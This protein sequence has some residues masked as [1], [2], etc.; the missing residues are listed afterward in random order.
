MPCK[1]LAKLARSASRAANA[2]IIPKL[3]PIES[4]SVSQASPTWKADHRNRSGTR[5]SPAA[6]RNDDISHRFGPGQTVLISRH[7]SGKSVSLV[8]VRP[9][10]HAIQAEGCQTLPGPGRAGPRASLPMPASP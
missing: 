10:R 2:N 6:E 3:M 7:R 1:Q 8:L 4:G 5:A 9:R